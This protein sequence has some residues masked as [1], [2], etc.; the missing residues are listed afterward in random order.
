MNTNDFIVKANRIHS[1]RY[2]YSMVNYVNC[3]EKIKIIC[4]VHGE[5]EQIASY[6][7]AGSNCP[8]CRSVVSLKG[9]TNFIT[10]AN[11]LYN[12]KYEYVEHTYKSS[13]KKVLIICPLHG[14]FNMSPD[15][16]LQ[17]RECSRC[18]LDVKWGE[19]L[20]LFKKIH[21]NKYDYSKTVFVDYNTKISITCPE[22][23]RI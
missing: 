5:F 8:L 14:Q 10:K 6:H 4:R 23:R 7:L 15:N 17:G 9:F 21:N 18:V 22:H 1:N 11:K 3:R 20:I 2:D 13:D 19:R 16:H 12:N